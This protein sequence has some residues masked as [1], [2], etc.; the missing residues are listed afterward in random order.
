MRGMYT[1]PMHP[2]VKLVKPGP[3]PICGMF[4]GKESS[5]MSWRFWI[6]LVLN[7]IY[8]ALSVGF[9]AYMFNLVKRKGT[10]VKL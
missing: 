3:C 1:C 7:V 5:A 8:F 10:L 4:V 6:A 2:Q 9:F